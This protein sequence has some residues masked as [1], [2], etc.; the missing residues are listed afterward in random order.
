MI[1]E[2]TKQDIPEISEFMA[3]FW[4]WTK[5]NWNAEDTAEYIDELYKSSREM[6]DKYESDFVMYIVMAG[7]KYFIAKQKGEAHD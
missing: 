6:A 5:H 7:I 3:D 2:A 1:I 4:N